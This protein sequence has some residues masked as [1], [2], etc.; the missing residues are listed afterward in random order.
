M[1]RLVATVEDI[2]VGGA[3]G[4]VSVR[5][6]TENPSTDPQVGAGVYSVCTAAGRFGVPT[7]D[8]EIQSLE[9][10]EPGENVTGV[11]EIEVPEDCGDVVV[12]VRVL[13]VTPG[14]DHIAEYPVTG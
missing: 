8:S 6:T 1:G 4:A 12:Q 14:G 3:D 9:T 11:A 13:A 10:L 5:M 2:E 7:A